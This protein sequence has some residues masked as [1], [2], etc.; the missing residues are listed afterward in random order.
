MKA[1]LIKIISYINTA[2][3][4]ILENKAMVFRTELYLVK[5]IIDKDNQVSLT[6]SKINKSKVFV[7]G[8]KNAVILNSALVCGTMITI[9]G[10]NNMLTIEPDVELINSTI[11]I[12]GNSCRIKI[13]RGTSFGGI[14]IVN[15]GINNSIDIGEN[16]LFSDCIELWAS[17]THSIFNSDGDFINP[18]RPVSIGNNVWVGSHVK[19]LKGVSIGEGAVIGMNTLVTKNVT[20][21]SLCAGNPMR[22]LKEDINWSPDYR[23]N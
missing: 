16:C 15:V 1:I 2:F 14:R 19:I 6:N 23:N 17:D 22:C 10:T 7:S 13:G 18:E 4:S 8:E 3:Y 21:K 5:F 11:N 9:K 12:R 20:P